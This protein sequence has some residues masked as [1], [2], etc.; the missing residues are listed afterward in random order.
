MRMCRSMATHGLLLVSR[1]LPHERLRQDISWLVPFFR[2]CIDICM[3]ESMNRRP[4]GN[5][6][7]ILTAMLK[8]L[9]ASPLST[10]GFF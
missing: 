5:T 1:D 3:I 10:L 4:L 2:R 7:F 8:A 9:D 6:I